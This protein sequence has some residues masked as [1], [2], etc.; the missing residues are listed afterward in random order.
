VDDIDWAS[1][2]PALK[3]LK[4]K[5][6]IVFNDGRFAILTK[7]IPEMRISSLEK[8]RLQILHGMVENAEVSQAIDSA[9]GPGIGAG[10]P[11][12]SVIV[13]S[14]NQEKYIAECLQGIFAQKGDCRIELVIGDD[15]STDSTLDV[16]RTYVNTLRHD[17]LDV[18]ILATDTNLGIPRNLKRCLEAC[19]GQYIAIC[20]GDDYWIDGHKLQVQVDFL[21]SHPECAMCFNDIHI[22]SQESGEFSAFELQQR[23]DADVLTTK[24]VVRDYVIGNYSCCMYDARYV[25][26]LPAGLFDL[27]LGDWMFNICYSQFG[28]IGHVKRKMSVYRKHSEGVWAGKPPLENA[29]LLHSYIDE[30]NRF[31]NYDL[32]VEFSIQ[33]KWLAAGWPG[34]FYKRAWDIA[35][36]DD[37]FPHPLSAFRVQEFESYLE[38]FDS[39]KIY[40]SGLSV[41]VLGKET[42]EELVAEFK[43]RRPEYAGQLEVLEADTVINARLIYMVFLGNAY[44]NIERI[45]D[46][47]TPFV[48]TLYPGGQFGLNNARSDMMLR[49]VT[50]SPCFRKVIVTQQVTYDYL[51]KKRFCAP[52]QIEFVFGVVT[53]IDGI[54]REQADKKHFGT[55][56]NVLDICFVG[57]KYVARGIDKGYDV[58]VEVARDLCRRYDDIQF[59]VVG[60]FDENEI[61]VT[62]IRERFTFYGTRDMTWFDEFYRDK[63]IVLSPNVPSMI[64]EGSFDGFPTGACVDAAL[65]K[66]AIF[67]ADD[68]H[69]NTHFVDGIDIVLIPHDAAR[70]AGI[71][72]RYY[73]DPEGLKRVAENGFRKMKQL[74]SFDAQMAPRISSL[75]EQVERA[76][77]SSPRRVGPFFAAT[78]LKMSVTLWR[79]C[80][81]SLRDRIGKAVK[82]IRSHEALFGVIKRSCPRSVI[83]LYRRFRASVARP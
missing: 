45:E 46:L 36:I 21:R 63:D 55:D 66:T 40:T 50:S 18:K 49:R 47:G 41:R 75:K 54:E 73:R 70:V 38:E 12:V 64:F 51:I 79:T 60:S 71:I 27:V 65:R 30:Y 52:N 62:D 69:L 16:V 28:D 22:Y 2:R 24:D 5:L 17:N 67:A 68:L 82:G 31:L 9:S 53:P 7:A 57:Y 4:G 78:A 48:F 19:T 77:S 1:V 26:A 61:D 59:H 25:R 8:Q 33:Q 13:L 20:E 83:R 29:K 56:K 39:V 34:E 44:S 81:Q 43:R 10:I 6:D 72:E 35:I 76:R 42:R 15:C 74:Y 14:Y 37:V 23:M 11:T 3:R 80:P 32:D 58:F